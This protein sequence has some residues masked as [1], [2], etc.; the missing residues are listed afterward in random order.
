MG[1]DGSERR[2]RRGGPTLNGNATWGVRNATG[3]F[4]Q[5][6]ATT[7]YENPI[8][9]FMV[10]QSGPAPAANQIWCQGTNGSSF[11]FFKD[12]ANLGLSP[13]A[14]SVP[15]TPANW[16]LV[17]IYEHNQATRASINNGALS[18]PGVA[19]GQSFGTMSG[20]NLG[21]QTGGGSKADVNYA[22]VVMTQGQATA[23]WLASFTAD[24]NSHF[25]LGLPAAP[26]PFSVAQG[27]LGGLFTP[28]FDYIIDPFSQSNFL[29]FAVDGLTE[30]PNANIFILGQDNTFQ[31]MPNIFKP[32]RAAWIKCPISR[33]SPARPAATRPRCVT[34]SKLAP[35]D[36]WSTSPAR[37]ADRSST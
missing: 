20:V 11:I 37:R 14:V 8:D 25:A 28:P 21:A 29:P 24:M 13:G 34:T 18:V 16:N 22:L 19:G 31:V 33:T 6:A 2:R 15:C 23:Q 17:R 1:R 4:L 35:V 5:S 10:V 36:H 30:A 12:A 3:G 7:A 27:S 26:A 9:V 32:S